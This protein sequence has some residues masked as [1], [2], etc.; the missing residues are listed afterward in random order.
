MKRIITLVISMLSLGLVVLLPVKAAQLNVAAIGVELVTPVKSLPG[1]ETGLAGL[2]QIRCDASIVEYE[3]FDETVVEGTDGN[4]LLGSLAV[5]ILAP[6]GIGGV[7]SA[8]F[9]GQMKTAVRQRTADSFIPEGSINLTLKE[10]EY[11][12]KTV[13]RTKI[14]NKS[15]SK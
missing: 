3:D 15:T 6:L 10:D 4:S 5:W 9:L 12:S 13:T 7:V 2:Q 1:Y 11:L 14:Q 8:I